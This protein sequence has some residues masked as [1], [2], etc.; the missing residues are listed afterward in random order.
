MKTLAEQAI[1][2]VL[3]GT[4]PSNVVAGAIFDFAGY[5]TTRP[6]S[7]PVGSSKDAGPMVGHIQKW[8]K[9][10]NLSLDNAD[11]KGWQDVTEAEPKKRKLN[12]REM[13]ALSAA[14]RHGIVS[15]GMDA[16]LNVFYKL[17]K[18]KLIQP[19]PGAWPISEKGKKALEDG[20]YYDEL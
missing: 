11:V 7:M 1:E 16:T 12:A 15:G 17:M 3:E 20:F 13:H 9:Q 10:R 8:A 4:A 14:A 2:K 19:G 18:A 6:E 5:L